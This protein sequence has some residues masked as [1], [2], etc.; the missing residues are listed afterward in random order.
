MATV[1]LSHQPEVPAPQQ[2][3]RRQS[4]ISPFP[5][6]SEKKNN[7]TPNKRGQ[8]INDQ[9]RFAINKE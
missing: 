7:T 3:R 8:S 9:M 6:P 5:V 1:G 2:P 4:E